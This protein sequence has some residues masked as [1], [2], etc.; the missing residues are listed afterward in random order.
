MVF[1]IAKSESSRDVKQI[2]EHFNVINRFDGR[3]SSEVGSLS[4][5]EEELTG[6]RASPT[7]PPPSFRDEIVSQVISS[8]LLW[9]RLVLV[10]SAFY[11]AS[12]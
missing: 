12:R 9:T 7:K 10:C 6:S 11:A 2:A 3:L 4:I 1:R 8:I 5:S